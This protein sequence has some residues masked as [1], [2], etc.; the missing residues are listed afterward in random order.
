M[1]GAIDTNLL[2]YA[3]DEASS[4]HLPARKFLDHLL[5]S[6]TSV[7]VTWDILH[8][9]LRIGTHSGVFSNPLAP[10]EAAE[11]IQK[12]LDHPAVGVLQAPSYESWTILTRLIKELHLRGNLIPDA[13]TA[14]ILEASGIQTIYTNDRDFWKFPGLKPVDP[15]K[16]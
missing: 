13:V 12:I 9:F 10:E 3:E 1:S 8:A 15:F 6:E 2:L 11:D 7:Y 5:E 14:S 4:F 16:H